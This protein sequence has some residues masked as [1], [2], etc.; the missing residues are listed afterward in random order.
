[1]EIAALVFA[2]ICAIAAA[3]FFARWQ[4][5]EV[6]LAPLE[7]EL[8]KLRQEDA[9]LA[10]ATQKLGI[11]EEKMKLLA[12]Q[13]EKEVKMLQ[14]QQP[15]QFEQL[16]AKILESNS[17]KLNKE[18]EKSL[19]ALLNPLR[20]KLGEFHKKVEDSFGAEA[21]ERHA[22]KNEI[23]NIVTA[24]EKMRVETENLTNA[25]RGSNKIQGNWGEHVLTM[26]L[27]SSG[28]REGTEFITQGRDMKLKSEDGQRLQPDV[29]V[30]LPENKH[31]IIDSKVS[32]THYEQ[33]VNA[34]DEA[35]RAQAMG[36]FVASVRAH[37]KGLA[38][39]DYASAEKLGTPDFVLMFMPIEGAHALALQ[40]D[41]ELF[42][43]AWD[44]KIAI[45]SPTT[46]MP[47]LKTVSSLWRRANQDRN[48]QEIA[49]QGGNLYDKFVTFVESMEE[50][51]K[52]LKQTESS[53]DKAMNRLTHGTGNLIARAEK[54]REL[55]AKTSKALPEKLL[56]EKNA[57]EPEKTPLRVVEN[58]G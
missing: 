24:H 19:G 23:A 26:L 55:G 32:L 42:P 47:I 1:M 30:L 22:L 16:A 20:E 12:A 48:Y 8:T 51:G 21:K 38:D 13:H 28:L 40:S 57:E 41:S 3:V 6:R 35:A 54:L 39:K 14:E 27:E 44:R 10:D 29:I 37:V 36:R 25:L 15:A 46:L 33:V 18:S 50:I 4:K 58:A 45:V 11:L 56:A 9:T 2:V 43:Y 17:A 52:H 5:A 7:K 49:R 31:L 53:Y 34:A